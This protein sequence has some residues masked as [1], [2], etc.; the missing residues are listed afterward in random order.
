MLLQL[1]WTADVDALRKE[2]D[3][4]LA[5]EGKGLWD[6]KLAKVQVVETSERTM[7]IRVLLGGSV[8]S[9]FDLRALV[10]ERLLAFARN[11]PDWLPQERVSPASPNGEDPR[12]SEPAAG[13]PGEGPRVADSPRPRG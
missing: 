13:R 6:G 5:D 7:Q 11:H 9:L 2:L 1:D 12:A 4:V 3:R 10:R 8:D